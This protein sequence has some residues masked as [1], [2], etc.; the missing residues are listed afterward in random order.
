[1]AVSTQMVPTGINTLDAC[2]SGGLPGGA[3]LSILVW[4]DGVA[5]TEIRPRILQGL[6]D[7]GAVLTQA[8]DD[9]ARGVFQ[10]WHSEG[11]PLL[12]EYFGLSPQCASAFF[13]R[14]GRTRRGARPFIV[15]TS[16]WDKIPRVLRYTSMLTVRFH[17]GGFR[18]VKARDEAHAHLQAKSFPL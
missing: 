9:R 2:L 14:E 10:K 12:V 16:E 5:E 7:G 1:M 4:D 8:S 15:F 18:V 17:E 13:M 6:L 3:S 11:P